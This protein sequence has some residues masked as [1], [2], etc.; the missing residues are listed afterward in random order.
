LSSPRINIE[1]NRNRLPS[2]GLRKARSA[3]KS[4]LYRLPWLYRLVLVASK[5]V[6]IKRGSWTEPELELVPIAISPGQTALDVGANYGLWSYHLARAVGRDGHVVAVEPIAGT[7]SALRRVLELLGVS[8]RVEVLAVAAGERDGAVGFRVPV[9]DGIPVAGL[10]HMVGV[11]GSDQPTM[12]TRACRLDDVPVP[13]ELALLK[14][15]VE[16]AE[17]YALRGAERLLR[18]HE[19]VIICEVGADLLEA[20]YGLRANQLTAYLAGLGYSPPMRYRAGRLQTASLAE[21]HDGNYVF[22]TPRRIGR[23]E[24]TIASRATA[25]SA[26]DSPGAPR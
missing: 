8:R 19:P 11:E 26:P 14:V 16:G 12:L 25:S 9:A 4:Q 21:H 6:A 20:R 23:L 24:A 3:V 18:E 22:A 2:V 1:L 7:A 13:G 17:F 5:T 15:D 10:A